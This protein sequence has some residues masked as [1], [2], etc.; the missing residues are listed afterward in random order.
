MSKIKC[1]EVIISKLSTRGKGVIGDPVRQITQVFSKSGELIAEMD[2]EKNCIKEHPDQK[3]DLRDTE[4]QQVFAAWAVRNMSTADHA[5]KNAP[6]LFKKLELE[7]IKEF[8]HQ[9]KKESED[10]EK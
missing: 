9:L 4:M 1:Q 3:I 10:A 6:E 2:P 7:D 5:F 8:I